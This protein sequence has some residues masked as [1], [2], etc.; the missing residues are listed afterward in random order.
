MVLFLSG[1]FYIEADGSLFHSLAF[2]GQ[3][4]AAFF[5]SAFHDG[6]GT[7]FPS[8]VFRNGVSRAVFQIGAA[9]SNS[10]PEPCSS[11]ANRLSALGT[12]RPSLSVISATT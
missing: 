12:T 2:Y 5:P 8:L 1:L 9:C 10:V 6:H 11:N 7:A 4:E 3:G